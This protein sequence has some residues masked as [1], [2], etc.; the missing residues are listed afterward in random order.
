MLRWSR[1]TFLALCGASGC[2]G[3]APP[4]GSPDLA[5][6][7]DAGSDFTAP[8]IDFSLPSR[9]PTNHPPLPLMSKHG[10]PVLKAMEIWTVVW[11]G[12]EDLGARIDRFHSWMLKSDYWNRSLAQYGVGPGRANGVIVLPSAAPA[13]MDV[14]EFDGLSS[15]LAKQHP[16][17]SN[18]V[19]AFVVPLTTQVTGG[20]G[21]NGC[22]SYGGYHT[23]TL[24]G[25]P[26]EVNLQ[27]GGEGSG[28]IDE[29]T[30]VLS[31]EA[32]E[33]ATDPRPFANPAW[34]SDDFANL[35]EVG[36][37]CNPLSVSL[38]SGNPP[39]D[40]GVTDDTYYLARLW[41]NKNASLGDLDPCVPIPMGE[42]YF[43]VGVN[44]NSGTATLDK[45]GEASFPIKFE[46]FSYGEVGTIH[47]QVMQGI[48][49]ASITPNHGIA[50]AGDTIAGVITIT[51]IAQPGTFIFSLSAQAQ[52]TGGSQQ[53]FGTLTIQ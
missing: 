35:G 41:S 5:Q 43:N 37:L 34:Y 25:L 12:E 27:C 52:K 47:W 8:P 26:Y 20:P 14:G 9:D 2:G 45:H 21:G 33:T 39:S 16:A 1:F 38:P 42:V 6:L 19:F 36:D 48:P 50:R 49:G 32:A 17:N 51:P 4:P 13:Q 18:T 40:G 22:F 44:P 15:M 29:L 28:G 53:W 10:G 30:F 11:P 23:Q 24:D 31:H 7:I 46:P 3:G